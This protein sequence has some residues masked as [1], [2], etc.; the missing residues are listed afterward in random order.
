[1]AISRRKD[2][3]RSSMKK[4]AWFSSLGTQAAGPQVG[5]EEEGGSFSEGSRA[6]H[7]RPPTLQLPPDLT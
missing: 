2:F 1:M 5:Q 7:S 6:V 4:A 3:F